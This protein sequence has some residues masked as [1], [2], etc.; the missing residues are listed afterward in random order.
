MPTVTEANPIP[1]C[2]RL[3]SMPTRD[4]ESLR[5]HGRFH[6]AENVPER[7]AWPEGEK[8]REEE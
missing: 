8:E 2:E 1:P 7:R 5:L 3:I 6:V 4:I